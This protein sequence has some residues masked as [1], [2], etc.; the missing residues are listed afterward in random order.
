MQHLLF[1]SLRPR[2]RSLKQKFYAGF[3]TSVVIHRYSPVLAGNMKRKRPLLHLQG[4]ILQH[5]VQWDLIFPPP[6][7]SYSTMIGSSDM[8]MLS[9]FAPCF[10]ITASL[11][12]ITCLSMHIHSGPCLLSPY[13]RCHMHLRR[14]MALQWEEPAPRGR[15]L[16]RLHQ[17]LA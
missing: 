1:I 11:A 8:T 7:S 13:L 3:C 4:A 16:R 17:R 5:F 6:N 14:P 15:T 12:S 2:R 10:V 9:A